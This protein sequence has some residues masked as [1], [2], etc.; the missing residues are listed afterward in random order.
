MSKCQQPAGSAPPGGPRAFSFALLPRTF[1]VGVPSL[2]DLVPAHPAGKT[3]SYE[4]REGRLAKGHAARDSGA[5][6]PLRRTARGA[7]P[8]SEPPAG[9]RRTP[10]ASLHTGKPDVWS[11]HVL[12][13]LV[14][15]F[16]TPSWRSRSA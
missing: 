5:P 3:G 2:G 4:D 14:S 15:D 7:L 16:E 11:N 9:V 13:G 6:L 12:D 8:P 1:P 10:C